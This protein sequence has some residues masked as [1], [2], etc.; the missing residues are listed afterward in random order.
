MIASIENQSFDNYEIIIVNDHSTDDTNEFLNTLKKNSKFNIINNSS[1]IGLQASRIKAA[2]LAKYEYII[3]LDDDDQMFPFCLENYYKIL[4]KKDYD[5]INT[6]YAINQ[7]IENHL[8]H[9]FLIKEYDD[10]N[11]LPSHKIHPKSIWSFV[12]KKKI[13]QSIYKNNLIKI[14]YG[15]DVVF[16]CN[17][18][19]IS[20]NF[21][22]ADFQ[23]ISY[24]KN[25]SSMTNIAK[26]NHKT[27]NEF[28]DCHCYVALIWGKNSMVTNLINHITLNWRYSVFKIIEKRIS[29]E[30]LMKF[31]IKF[32]DLYSNFD[33]DLNQKI[34]TQ[35]YPLSRNYILN[36]KKDFL[37][38]ISN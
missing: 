31:K 23:S 10:F 24:N 26:F 27:I 2:A 30:D 28:I 36:Q 9:N 35:I 14:D 37:K 1:N 20:N 29:S 13:V 8:N 17:L 5:F 19:K 22:T 18:Y 11:N 34:F 38:V 32:N 6:N 33:F 12:V 21:A 7:S 25:Y 16:I 4:E 3:Q 15:E